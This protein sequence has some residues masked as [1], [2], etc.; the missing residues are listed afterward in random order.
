M[1]DREYD[2]SDT[3]EGTFRWI[4]G[5]KYPHDGDEK[6]HTNLGSAGSTFMEWLQDEFNGK[7]IFWIS[8]KP[9]SG[10]STLMKYLH[11]DSRSKELLKD[12]ADYDNKLIVA[13]FYFWGASKSNFLKS[14]E[15]LLRSLMH[16]ILGQSTEI[17]HTVLK[18]KMGSDWSSDTYIRPSSITW[19]WQ[20]LKQLFSSTLA[21]MPLNTRLYMF[22]DGLDE[23][24]VVPKDASLHDIDSQS[25]VKKSTGHR[26]IAD[27][28]IAAAKSPRVK[29][30]LSSR[31]LNVFVRKFSDA[32]RDCLRLKLH[33]LTR[34]DI[35]KV[36]IGR[37]SGH[38]R[39]FKLE[40]EEKGLEAYLT[41]AVVHRSEGV[42][43]WVDIVTQR[44]ISAL[45]NGYDIE[46]LKEELDTIPSELGGPNGLF[47]LML[48]DIDVTQRGN[49]GSAD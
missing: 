47:M 5:H 8:G 10:K 30:C 39:L 28:F 21:N 31:E 40:R 34:M 15:A 43:L 35:K 27:L 9:A 22:V 23:Y 36:V 26:E 32:T 11:Q 7:R 3:H 14:R 1:H 38:P 48:K 4:L 42:F 20:E 49:A 18:S 41:D 25:E 44:L 33:T 6:N 16:Q 29:M 19:S 13:G 46:Q 24:R 17:M 37:L 45:E 12:W 2:V